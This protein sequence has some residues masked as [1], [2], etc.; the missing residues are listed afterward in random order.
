[1]TNVEGLWMLFVLLGLLAVCLVMTVLLIAVSG[2]RRWTDREM[3]PWSTRFMTAGGLLGIGLAVLSWLVILILI[4]PRGIVDNLADL[5][6]VM[7][8]MLTGY[9]LPLI[10][11]VYLMGLQRDDR[12]RDVVG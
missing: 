9:T 12:T 7:I 5:N 2:W 6:P 10:V 8:V 4:T 11:G 1:M 3:G